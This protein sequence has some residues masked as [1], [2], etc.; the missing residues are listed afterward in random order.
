MCRRLLSPLL[1][2]TVAALSAC[3]SS[4]TAIQVSD[5][6][7][8][9]DERAVWVASR[10]DGSEPGAALDSAMT[11]QVL[12]EYVQYESLLGLLADY[13][14][15]PT[16]ADLAV[17]RDQLIAT[18]IPDTAP[19]F[20]GLTGWQA[21]INLVQDGVPGARAAFDDHTDLI[22][23]EMCT[24]HILVPSLEDAERVLEMLDEGSTF[25]QLAVALSQDPGSGSRGGNLGCVA[26][27]DFVGEFERAVLGALAAG[28]V[29]PGET[30]LEPV[31]SQFGFHVIRIDAISPVEPETF[32][33]AAMRRVSI[34]TTMA[35]ITGDV[36]IDPRYGTWDPVRGMVVPP[37]GPSDGS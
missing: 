15:A 3:G 9:R 29:V 8:D 30:V 5:A 24:S 28:D 35:T 32:D 14:V 31:M 7:M 2:V 4:T 34:L 23:H 26:V 36:D 22:A 20:D 33:G 21:A 12:Q 18:G 13:G 6:S 1:L 16:D 17:A 25:V 10:I 19:T 11:A 27:G 37:A